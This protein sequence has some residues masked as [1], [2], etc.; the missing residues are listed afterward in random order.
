MH[1]SDSGS[2]L[3][4][5]ATIS[6]NVVGMRLISLPHWNKEL[7]GIAISISK[8]FQTFAQLLAILLA[9]LQVQ[10]S[11]TTKI[12]TAKFSETR[13][14]VCLAKVCTPE[15]YQPYHHMVIHTLVCLTTSLQRK[16]WIIWR[17]FDVV[18]GIIVWVIQAGKVR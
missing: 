16:L 7:A 11:P 10:N 18:I 6:M 8:Q 4:V 12:K 1:K 17:Q 15:N 13:I 3:R 9:N 5:K 2:R 14:L